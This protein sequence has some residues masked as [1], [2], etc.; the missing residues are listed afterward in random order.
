MKKK[1]L[2]QLIK[3]NFTNSEGNIDLSDLDFGDFKGTLILN[4]IKSEGC[5]QQSNH[6]NKGSIWQNNIQ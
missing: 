1:K 5:I 4:G 3:E 6:S 2:V